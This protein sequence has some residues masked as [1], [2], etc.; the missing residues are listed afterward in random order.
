[1]NT[2][3]TTVQTRAPASSQKAQR[4]IESVANKPESDHASLEAVPFGNKGRS[5]EERAYPNRRGADTVQIISLKGRTA[6]RSQWTT[7][8]ARKTRQP[9]SSTE[10][11][12]QSR[13]EESQLEAKQ[14]R[15][16]NEECR[17]TSEHND[18]DADDL[19]KSCRARN[20]ESRQQ[21]QT[22]ANGSQRARFPYTKHHH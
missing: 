22:P 17:R 16:R 13:N 6:S 10:S 20:H 19:L 14:E 18:K 1:M 15:R 12:R 4:T 9:K 8:A 2:S 3:K 7:I 21:N 11:Q 5:P